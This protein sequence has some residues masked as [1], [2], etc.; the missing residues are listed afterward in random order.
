[1][2]YDGYESLMRRVR[3]KQMNRT[4]K[5]YMFKTRKNWNFDII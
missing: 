1:M 3:F 4:K 5:N 2:T